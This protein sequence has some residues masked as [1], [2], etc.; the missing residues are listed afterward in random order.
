MRPRDLPT[1]GAALLF[2]TWYWLTVAGQH[3]DSDLNRFRRLDRT[4]MLLPNWRFFAP[5]PGVT[6]THLLHRVRLPDGSQTPWEPTLQITRRT[7]LHA[8]WFPGR[9]REKSVFDIAIHLEQLAGV[10]DARRM[11]DTGSY[12]LLAGFVRRTV[13]ERYAEPRAFQFALVRHTGF[14]QEGEPEYLLRSSYLPMTLPPTGDGTTH[15]DP[16]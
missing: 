8:M 4:G 3:T 7:W 14:E 2:G 16:A 10:M 13:A 15:R 12:G 11:A 5:S 9:R 6:D 1:V